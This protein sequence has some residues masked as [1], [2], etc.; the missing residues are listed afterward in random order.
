ML[1][2]DR[3]AEPC[4]VITSEPVAQ[5]VEQNEL[6]VDT[7][8]EMLADEVPY[9]NDRDW[10]IFLGVETGPDC[11]GLL[12]EIEMRSNSS[13][14]PVDVMFRDL[15]GKAICSVVQFFMLTEARVSYLLTPAQEESLRQ[16]CL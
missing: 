11:E 1:G 7:V 12:D 2:R 16:C 4:F 8:K 13:G 14:H 9:A 3:S 6:H 15:D 5:W 10:F